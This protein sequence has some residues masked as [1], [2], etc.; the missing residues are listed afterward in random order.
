MFEI[1]WNEF[2]D[3]TSKQEG[4]FEPGST[5]NCAI[6]TFIKSKYP[7][8]HFYVRYYY[9]LATNADGE[10]IQHRI[11]DDIAEFIEFVDEGNP[12]TY[13]W[14]DLAVELQKMGYGT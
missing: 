9:V 12:E 2:A 11:P 8:L 7:N 14:A 10:R 6:A 5:G 3:F 13:P 1:D 4:G